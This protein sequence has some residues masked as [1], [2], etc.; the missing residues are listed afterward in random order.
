M[1]DT[2]YGDDLLKSCLYLQSNVFELGDLLA[3]RGE[4]E[5]KRSARVFS[6]GN[7]GGSDSLLSHPVA[8]TAGKW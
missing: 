8:G 5:S 3:L 2:F 7:G 4:V 6:A 1:T